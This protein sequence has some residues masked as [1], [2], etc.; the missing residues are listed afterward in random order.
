MSS[1]GNNS[2]QTNRGIDKQ[3]ANSRQ[4]GDNISAQCDILITVE[5]IEPQHNW[6]GPNIMA[7]SNSFVFL[8]TN[9]SENG[10]TAFSNLSSAL[11]HVA[12]SHG[13]LNAEG[14]A[15]MFDNGTNA[16]V[17][18]TIGNVK[19]SYARNLRFVASNADAASVVDGIQ[20]KLKGALQACALVGV[21]P[22]NVAKVADLRA[23]L[24]T[25]QLS[26]GSIEDATEFNIEVLVLHKRKH[27]KR[28]NVAS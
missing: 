10:T 13:D 12:D 16:L 7:N 19:R 15:L 8:V 21:D 3:F 4:D 26:I 25:A 17:P 28:D 24:E 6:I 18:A 9:T 2:N 27:T 5:A 1:D 23:E 11:T 14:A 22:D 20:S